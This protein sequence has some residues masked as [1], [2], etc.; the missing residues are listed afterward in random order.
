MAGFTKKTREEVM[1][2]TSSELKYV[3]VLVEILYKC[4]GIGNRISR[5]DID[6]KMI[7]MG[8]RPERVTNILAHIRKKNLVPCLV[9]Y[10]RAYYVATTR[11][12]M[13]DYIRRID[14]TLDELTRQVEELCTLK[15]A[16]MKQC[17]ERFGRI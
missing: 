7:V 8:V 1:E 15:D 17:K 11:S 4:Q 14:Y 2:L 10:R 16:A 12:D 6:S 13:T 5:R 9:T 3:P